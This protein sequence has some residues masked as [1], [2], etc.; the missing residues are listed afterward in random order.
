MSKY[1]R[2]ICELHL[3]IKDTDARNNVM[4]VQKESLIVGAV[5]PYDGSIV[6]QCGRRIG[7][8][9]HKF[10]FEEWKPRRND[11]VFWYT[12]GSKQQ[13]KEIIREIKQEAKY[14]PIC[15]CAPFEEEIM[16]TSE[17]KCKALKEPEAKK[18]LDSEI[19]ILINNRMTTTDYHKNVVTF[20]K[21]CR[22][23]LYIKKDYLRG[24]E[25]ED[26]RWEECKYTLTWSSVEKIQEICYKFLGNVDVKEVTDE[27]HKL[28]GQLLIVQKRGININDPT[29]SWTDGDIVE[30][31]RKRHWDAYT[32]I[33]VTEWRKELRSFLLLGGKV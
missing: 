13:T 28:N 15:F 22:E 27:S 2:C 9:A 26:H 31:G 29:S 8:E 1:L 5:Y 23:K 11:Y 10:A 33:D 18:I 6:L 21:N 12:E 30:W 4:A 7:Y 3:E 32:T 14:N 20:I 16:K 19:Q 25:T 24:D 17:K